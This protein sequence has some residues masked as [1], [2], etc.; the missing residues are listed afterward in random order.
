M[1]TLRRILNLLSNL[2][3]GG[4]AAG[5]QGD[6]SS[7]ASSAQAAAQ[8]AA[9]EIFAPQHSFQEQLHFREVD[10]QDGVGK[11]RQDFYPAGTGFI[12]LHTK[13]KVITT[14]GAVVNTEEIAVKC[15]H[16]HGYDSEAH[17][18][19][20]GRALC[21]RCKRD[22]KMPEGTVQTLC[23]EH[24]RLARDHYDTWASYDQRGKP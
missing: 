4:P 13:T 10:A 1:E 23:P 14:T 9:D 8:A 16:C 20:C 5:S 19:Q 18:C 17:A 15:S 11:R 3:S 7:S 24:Y 6:D 21:R 22:L 2:W 12:E